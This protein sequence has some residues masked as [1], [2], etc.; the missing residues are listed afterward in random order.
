MILPRGDEVIQAGDRIVVIGSPR[1][2]QAVEPADRT[3]RARPVARDV[4]VYGAGRV[5]TAIAQLLL[6]QGIG[7]RLIEPDREPSAR[8]R[9]AA[10]GRP[11]LQRDR[12]STPDFLERERI[13]HAQA[14]VFAMREDDAEPLRGDARQGAR[15]RRSRSRS[16]TTPLSMPV[17][18]AAG[19]D[20]DRRTRAPSPPRRSSA[21]PTTRARS[22][23]RCSRATA[24]RCS[25]SSR[26]GERVRRQ[27]LPRHA[28]PR[29]ADRRDRPRRRGDLPARR[30]R[31]RRPATA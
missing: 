31:A 27:A 10:P 7:V 26:A 24:T 29:R 23:W 28:D 21:S 9:R 13:G 25:T 3:R 20:V 12:A 8:G 18:E 2:A 19:V 17:F 15:R 14:A 16:C 1:A 4:V 5:G 11:R 22:R 30:R 6:E